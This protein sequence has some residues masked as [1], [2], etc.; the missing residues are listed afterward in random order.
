[1]STHIINANMNQKGNYATMSLIQ[2]NK[3]TMNQIC[4]HATRPARIIYIHTHK[5][6]Q[7]ISPRPTCNSKANTQKKNPTHFNKDNTYQKGQ[8]ISP[9]SKHVHKSNTHQQGKHLQT[10]PTLNNPA[11]THQQ[12][13]HTTRQTCIDYVNTH[14]LGQHT[15]PRPSGIIMAKMHQIS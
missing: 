7:H 3:T 1:M 11:N 4:Q 8:Y 12:R 2:Y 5:Q 9:C 6:G 13:R 14:P 15:S 10:R